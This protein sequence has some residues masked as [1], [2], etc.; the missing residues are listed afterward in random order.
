MVGMDSIST[1]VSAAAERSRG[2]SGRVVDVALAGVLIAAWMGLIEALV[3]VLLRDIPEESLF[4]RQAVLSYAGFGLC[5]GFVWG[6]FWGRVVPWDPGWRRGT[7]FVPSLVVVIL[8]FQLIALIHVHRG[9]LTG[10]SPGSPESLAIIAGVAIPA[11]VSIGW[12][13][14]RCRKP[15]ASTSRGSLASRRVVV[16]LTAPLLL[17]VVLPWL[18]AVLRPGARPDLPNVVLIVLDTTRADRLSAYGYS[19]ST[20]PTLERIAAEGLRFANASAAAPWTLPSHASM[21]T[22]QYPAVHN[23]TWEH[24][25]LD[26]RLPTLAEHLA[27]L[28]LRTASFSRQPWLTD[29][30]GLMRGFEHAYDLH[31]RSSTA[32]V[33]VYRLALDKVNKR[34][35]T[36]DKGAAIVSRTFTRWIERNG[37]RPFFAFLN[38]TE[39][40]DGYD[41]PHPFREQYLGENRETQWGQSKQAD[42]QRFNAGELRY[43]SEDLAIFNDLYDGA[44]AYQDFRLGEVIDHLRVRELLDKTLLIITADHGENLGDHGMLSHYFCLYNT[45]LHAPLVIR[46][47][48]VVPSGVVVEEPVENRLVW[49]LIDMVLEERSVEGEIPVDRFVSALSAEDD[50]GGPILAELYSRP[51]TTE[52]WQRSPRRERYDRRLRSIVLGKMK[53]IWASSGTHELYD[54]DSDPEESFNLIDERPDDARRL[55]EIL[56]AKVA[57]LESVETGDGPEFSDAMKE[58]LKALG[59]IE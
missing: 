28:G 16:I 4:L 45:L 48:G 51:L 49:S 33:D 50:L 22:G 25:F 10:V 59:Y 39:P 19:R 36:N 23:A 30:T 44:V 26:T 37:D 6:G 1:P 27:D 34:R 3:M 13:W 31:W 20:T 8:A 43:S 46:M 40:H 14:R 7:F 38:F 58:R 15:G 41:P 54:L 2:S 56:E 17:V 11:V 55:R 32:L 24:Q 29:E 18:M 5:V 47:P 9:G 52:I 21:F 35:G 12:F 57:A 42:I 53:Y